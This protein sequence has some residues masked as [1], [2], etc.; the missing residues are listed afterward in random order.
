MSLFRIVKYSSVLFFLGKYKLKLF[1]VVAVLLFALMTSLLYQDIAGYLQQ[2]HPETVIVA[3]IA[4]VVIV[5]GALIFVLLQFRPG[6][7][8][9]SPRKLHDLEG[10]A[11]E[12]SVAD[13]ARDD[14]LAG[15]EDITKK[16]TLRT[17]YDKVI[18]SAGKKRG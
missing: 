16:A 9:G 2:Q 18:D 15:L 5:Y 12:Q 10:P 7:A 11:T 3:L 14:R 13:T 1:R 17:R 4:K 6:S 8:E